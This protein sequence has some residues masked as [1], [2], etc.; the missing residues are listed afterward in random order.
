MEAK[1][2]ILVS[3]TINMHEVKQCMNN[4]ESDLS[5][6]EPLVIYNIDIWLS[7]QLD[8]LIPVRFTLVKLHH[9]KNKLSSDPSVGKHQLKL[10]S[11]NTW[12]YN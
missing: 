3:E 2:A 11:F 7:Y 9:N 1:A 5:S 10:H 4:L 8:Y 12:Q 6:G